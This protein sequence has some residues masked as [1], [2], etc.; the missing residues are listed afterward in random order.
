MITGFTAV[1]QF[2]LFDL[3]SRPNAPFQFPHIQTSAQR[4]RGRGRDTVSLSSQ[5]A[6]KFSFV[7][8]PECHSNNL[9]I[10]KEN[11][12]RYG[13]ESKIDERFHWGGFEASS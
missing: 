1:C 13:I 12:R 7:V 8:C 11:E 5:S 6:S 3:I 2:G 10:L 4:Q 9:A